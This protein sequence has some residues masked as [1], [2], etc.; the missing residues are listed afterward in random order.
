MDA[1]YIDMEE[2]IEDVNHLKDLKSQKTA[3]ESQISVLEQKII[4]DY[5]TQDDSKVCE[6]TEN[7]VNLESGVG[8]KLTY[9]I[10][11]KINEDKLA[12]LCEETGEYPNH[13]CSVKY[14]YSATIFK[15]LQNEEKQKLLG[16]IEIK[17]AKTSVELL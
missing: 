9:K 6:G 15:G 11:R 13:F 17:K 4:S 1:N 12:K 5:A 8:V 2:F 14:G 16:I 10:T 7:L 3:I